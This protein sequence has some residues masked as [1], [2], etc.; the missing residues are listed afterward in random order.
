MLVGQDLDHALQAEVHHLPAGPR[1]ER[2]AR[3]FDVTVEILFAERPNGS[4]RG[5][6]Y[7]ALAGAVRSI[8][9][10]A[11]VLP[12]MATGYTDSRFFRAAGVETYG[13]APLLLPRGEFGRIHG[14]DERIPLEGVRE[15]TAI[16]SALIAGWNAAA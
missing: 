5:P 9:P 4:P 13:L 3:G 7:D 1:V 2:L 12:Y 10:D 14:V 11:L 8:H 15:M 16:I 6:L